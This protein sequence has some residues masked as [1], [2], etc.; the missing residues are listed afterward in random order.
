MVMVAVIS[1][2]VSTREIFEIPNDIEQVNET[3]LLIAC[4]L[5]TD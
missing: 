4:I 2:V 3:P 5:L 1:M